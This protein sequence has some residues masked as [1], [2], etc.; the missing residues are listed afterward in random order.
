MSNAE[1]YLKNSHTDKYLTAGRP[2]AD[3]G[4][5]VKANN[6]RGR[7]PTGHWALEH[8]D[9]R[10]TLYILHEG[11]ELEVNADGEP[12]VL[13]IVE[14]GGSQLAGMWEICRLFPDNPNK[15]YL[16]YINQSRRLSAPRGGAGWFLRADA[17]GRVYFEQLPDVDDMLRD[18]RRH[19]ATYKSCIWTFTPY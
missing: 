2:R 13:P 6:K 4:R 15:F 16:R 10:R 19:H 9:H 11:G 14:G 1:G 3:R 12:S 17:D 5:K 8:R 18:R 7:F